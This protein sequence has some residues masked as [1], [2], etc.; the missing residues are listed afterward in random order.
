MTKINT[1]SAALLA[2][3]YGQKA[4]TKML[5]PMER[6]S[7]GLRINSAS[8]DAAGLAVTNKMTA[9]IKD[10]D[11]SVRNS[12]DMISLLNAAEGSL[13]QISAIQTRLMEIAVQSANGVYTQ[14]DRDAM[15]LELIALVAEIDRIAGNTKFNDVTLLDGTYN[16]V[17]HGSRDKIPVNI[18]EFGTSTVGRYWEADDFENNNF[19]V[20][21]PIVSIS[22][23]ESRFPGWA[24]HNK[25]VFLGQGTDLGSTVIG[26][27]RAPIDPTPTPHQNVTGAGA[28]G[29][30]DEGPIGG[31]AVLGTNASSG[32]SFDATG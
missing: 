15:E 9:S 27:Y 21:G 6:L 7:S 13:S 22:D 19:S 31:G 28:T 29:L 12:V 24:V 26:G 20:Q 17:G 11:L 23:T 30:N 32:F 3:A 25:R 14:Q 2:R 1:N 4:N 5:K 18:G 8:D 10:Y 16:S